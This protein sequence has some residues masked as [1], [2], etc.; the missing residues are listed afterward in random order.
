MT[1]IAT[2]PCSRFGQSCMR[3]F[4]CNNKGFHR[5]ASLRQGKGTGFVEFCPSRPMSKV[6]GAAVSTTIQSLQNGYG[7]TVDSQFRLASR[8]FSSSPPG[9]TEI[10]KKESNGKTAASI[11]NKKVTAPFLA[12]KKRHGQKITMVTAYDYPS[13]LHVDRAGIDVLLI[14]DSVGMVELG[15]ET[16]QPVTME[17]MLHHCKAVRRGANRAL[18]VGDMP[19]GSYEVDDR[20]A[21]RNAYRFIKEAG[22]DAIKME[23]GSATR[24]QTVQKVVGGGVAVMGHVGLLPQAISVIGGFRAQGRTAVRAREILDE[25]LRLQDAGAFAVVLE[26]VPA[27]VAKAVEE[28]LEIPTIGIGAGPYTTGQVLVYHDML[29]MTSHPHHQHF[30]PKFCKKYAR[31][32]DAITKGLEEF[33][34]DVEESNFP[35]TEF[36]PYNMTEKEESLF[37]SDLERDATE[38]ERLHEEAASRLKNADEY[39]ALDLYGYASNGSK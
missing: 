20:E 36:S 30:V 34:N 11:A 10:I 29:G 26:C 33:K 21:L 39:E 25:A 24:A 14:G 31:V 1:T 37:L 16:T 6:L 8:Q 27:P 9:M 3:L 5:G 23:G 7:I 19:L 18:L 35:G 13:A 22:M 15:Y 2:H 38:R 17:E 32:G 4:V 12:S 28:T